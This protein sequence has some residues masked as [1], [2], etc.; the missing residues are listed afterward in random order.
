M[1]VKG[2]FLWCLLTITVSNGHGSNDEEKQNSVL[3]RQCG[4]ETSSPDLLMVS[5][6]SPFVLEKH[7]RTMFGSSLSVPVERLRNPAGV[8]FSV[9][10]FSKAGCQGVGPWTSD[11]TWYPGHSWRV[12]LCPQC[13]QHMGWMFEPDLSDNLDTLDRPSSAGFY[14][15]IV[16]KVIDENF[17]NSITMTSHAKYA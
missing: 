1:E 9:I 12:C 15:L 6:L 7:N 2:V 10:T 8:E 17:A 11:H 4:R 5:P 16:S 14:A 3:C 13:G